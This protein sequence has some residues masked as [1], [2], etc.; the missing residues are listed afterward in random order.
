MLLRGLTDGGFFAVISNESHPF[1]V[2]RLDPLMS[3]VSKN[4]RD[5]IKLLLRLRVCGKFEKSTVSDFSMT[6]RRFIFAS[7]SFA[8][9]VFCLIKS[10]WVIFLFID[11]SVSFCIRP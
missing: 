1:D 11:I 3:G 6:L 5:S 9:F 2:R 7:E 4:L 8:V 10:A